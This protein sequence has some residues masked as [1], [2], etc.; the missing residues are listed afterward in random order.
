M[1][2]ESL[3]RQINRNCENYKYFWAYGTVKETAGLWN[4][5]NIELLCAD[6][7]IMVEQ[8]TA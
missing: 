5:T 2:V 8:V 4:E 3:A 7:R 6:A 1:T